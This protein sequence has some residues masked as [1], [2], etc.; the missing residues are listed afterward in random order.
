MRSKPEMGIP[1]AE[2]RALL[3]GLGLSN[4]EMERPFVAVVNSWSEFNPGH[5]HLNEVAQKVKEGVREAGG[6]PFEVETLGLCDGLALINKRYILP[7]RDLIANEVEVWVQANMFDAMVMICTCDKIVPGYLM[8]AARINI[9]TVI[10]TGGYMEPG[11]HDGKQ[12]TFVEA[13]KSIGSYLEGLIDRQTMEEIVE[14]SC[15]PRGACTLMGTANTMCMVSE[16]LG[17]SLPGNGTVSAASSELLRI[18]RSAG[19]Q[20]MKLYEQQVVPRDIITAAAVENAVKMVMAI[21]GSSNALVHIPAI[22]AEAGLEL[23][24]LELF[25]K[26]SHSTPLLCEVVPNGPHTMWHL[27]KA[28][29]SRAVTAELL[30]LLDGAAMTVTG[31]TVAEN[32]QGALT[33]DESVIHSLAEPAASEGGI[34]VLKGNLAQDGAVVKQSA[35]PQGLMRF[36]GRAKAYS[37]EA[38]ALAALRSGGI[39][40]GDAIFILYQ[41]AKGAPGLATVYGFTSELAGTSLGKKVALIT[42]GRFSGATEGLSIGHV[43]PEAALG[44]TIAAVKDGDRVE[45]DV[46]ARRLELMVSDEEIAERLKSWVSPTPQLTGFLGQYQKLVTSLKEGAR[47]LP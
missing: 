9:P 34:A 47:L 6:V 32:M 15:S 38:E 8:A 37:S 42:D 19:Q 2:R 27:D 16:A 44:G 10:V 14:G 5:S 39:E 11:Y 20:V 25:D 12:I 7:S 35:V 3:K 45:I 41:G 29:G 31:K 21:G 17:M 28:G 22:A 43:T 33:R 23:D 30:P 46:T 26:A 36:T 13:G 18:A 24:C 1:W 4:E 40:A